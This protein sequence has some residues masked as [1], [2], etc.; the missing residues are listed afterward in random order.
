MERGIARLAVLSAHLE[1]SD[2]VLPP[3]IE[4]W[5]TSGASEPHGSL[6]GSLTIVDERTGKKYQV[7]VAEDG[8]VKSIDL[9][10]ITMG[11]DDKG[12]KLYD[13]G[14]LNT[15][16][17]RS[18]ISYI[19]GDEGIL[20]YR[21]YPIEE[22]AE[23]STFL[24]VAYL[25]IYGNLPSKSQLADWELAISQHS[26]V[27]QGLLD[28]IQSMPQDAYPTS[29]FDSAMSALSLFHPDA[30]PA[31]MGP[32]VYKSGQVRDK[33]IF[34]ILGQAPTIAAAAFLR[35]VGKP[36][37]L[38]L[39][40]LS[41]TEN[42]L[43]MLNS[44]G[45]RYYKPNPRLARVMDI[46]FILHCEHEMNCSTAAARHLSSSGVDVY[47][48]I[49]GA[50]GALNGA[51]HGGAVEAVPKMLSEIGSVENI[52]EFIECVKNK[53][54]KLYGFGHRIYR[55]Y[56]PRAKFLKKL[57]D[58]VFSIV[59]KDPLVEVAV[60][61]EKTA[62]SNEYF[63]RRKLYPNVDFYSGL[64]YRAMGVPSHFTRV[65]R[66]AGYLSHWRES[67]DDPDTKIMRPQQAYNGVWLRHYEP[68]RE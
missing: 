56:D 28:M 5:C 6:K 7:P 50:T 43:Y 64:V 20:R 40:N 12:I 25:L 60:A 1:V 32:D 39:S 30:N 35:T 48:A 11:K 34:R 10:K 26:A 15:A 37:V 57:A 29:A 54:R 2:Q 27:P 67:L 13:P 66:L 41:Y 38:P 21:G 9:K 55:N 33:Q 52:P 58:E 14:Y 36:P 53:K 68:V 61:L 62:L 45:N 46:I 47:T 44:M 4:P 42:L 8:T 19:D 63:V 3:A 16:P 65:S 59:G 18:S 17:V 51:L 49:G 22:L 31:H 23:S 24:E